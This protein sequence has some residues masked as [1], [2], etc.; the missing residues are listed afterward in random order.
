MELLSGLLAKVF[1]F[2]AASVISS[3]ALFGTGAASE[4]PKVVESVPV[5]EVVALTNAATYQAKTE[6]TAPSPT[7]E[8]FSTTVVT[9]HFAGW[10]ES[11]F[12]D[13]LDARFAGLLAHVYWLQKHDNDVEVSRK[14]RNEILAFV[15]KQIEKTADNSG[16]SDN[17]LSADLSA[18]D[19]R[20]LSVEADVTSLSTSSPNTFLALTDTPNSYTAGRVMFTDSGATA[21]IDSANFTFDGTNLGLGAQS[22]IAFGGTN[23]LYASST[24]DSIVFGENAGATFTSA[25]TNNIAIG[26]GA[27]RYASTTGADTNAYV[28]YLAGQNNTGSNNSFL[29]PNAGFGNIGS[30]NNI[31]GNQ[32]GYSSAASVT[33]L[34]GYQAGQNNTGSYSNLVGY[35]AG[36]NNTGA[37]NNFFGSSA[38]LNNTGLQNNFSGLN[39]GQDNTGSYNNAI[40]VNAAEN[41]TGSYNNAIGYNAALNNTGSYNNAI[42]YRAGYNNSSTNSNLIGNYAGF[43]NSGTYNDLIGYQSGFYLQSTSSVAIGGEALHGNSAFAAINNVAVGFEAGYNAETGAD[44]NIFI[45]YQSAMNVTSGANNIVIGYAVNIASTTGSNQLNIG[46]LI[47]GTDIDGLGSSISTGNIGIGTTT[48]SEKLTV[49]GTIQSTALLG[50]STN[51]TTDANGNIIRDPSDAR[52]KENVVTLDNALET[53]LALRGVRYQWIDKA[54]FGDQTEIG[55]IAQEVNEVVPE[56]V[57]QGGEYWSLN[58]K[59]LVAVVVEAIKE[60][61]A[62]VL[63]HEERLNELEAENAVLKARLEAVEAEVGVETQPGATNDE[64][65]PE[66]TLAPI[67]GTTT[68]TVIEP[69]PVTESE[70]E[71]VVEEVEVVEEVPVEQEVVVEEVVEEPAI[72][73]T[74]A[75]DPTPVTTTEGQ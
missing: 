2:L 51:L 21:L 62:R 61:W 37:H 53:V 26:F 22:K 44:N 52:L 47:F 54:R 57:L 17:D 1:N 75:P 38:G 8:L 68:D 69:A 63:G 65:Q 56:V 34:I 4:T 13:F 41:N 74:P 71:P 20:L 3:L 70:T 66:E 25:T 15:D 73:S 59:N 48:P 9:P 31:I 55:F 58:S 14:D 64:V 11:E 16:D 72:E 6:V 43:N 32:A 19:T 33:N 7:G 46:N 23:Y 45:G 28:G 10:S 5:A 42:G 35:L 12:Q 29:G 24:N 18:L 67:V 36:Q 50:G 27:G 49:D 30:D 39:S 60:I 40:G